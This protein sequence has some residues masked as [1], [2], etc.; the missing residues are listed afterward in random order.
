MTVGTPPHPASAKQKVRSRLLDID[1]HRQRLRDELAGLNSD[2]QVGAELINFILDL[3]AKPSGLY[4]KLADSGRRQ[5]NQAV[6]NKIYIHRHQVVADDINEPFRQI[7]HMER[8]A[9]RLGRED[10]RRR[11]RHEAPETETPGSPSSEDGQAGSLS[12]TSLVAQK[13]IMLNQFLRVYLT[14]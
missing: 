2:I 12:K 7:V 14:P 1:L 5:L 4:E 3:L 6:F 11:M 8:E 9:R 10:C 13:R